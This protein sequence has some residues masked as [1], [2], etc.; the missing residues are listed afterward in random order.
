MSHGAAV[1][2]R[3]GDVRLLLRVHRQ[4]GGENNEKSAQGLLHGRPLAV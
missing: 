1:A 3:I 4:R 2:F